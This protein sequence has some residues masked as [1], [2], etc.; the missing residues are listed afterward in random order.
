M[1][2]I[3]KKRTTWTRATPAKQEWQTNFGQ[4]R[5]NGR[6]I[7]I[8]ADSYQ[9]RVSLCNLHNSKKIVRKFSTSR[10]R[11]WWGK[12]H[13][14][15]NENSPPQQSQSPQ[16][17]ETNKIQNVRQKWSQRQETTTTNI[18]KSILWLGQRPIERV[19]DYWAKVDK[20]SRAH[21]QTLLKRK[22]ASLFSFSFSFLKSVLSFP[23][24]SFSQNLTK[25]KTT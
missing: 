25:K 9:F 12:R 7:I 21:T 1:T 11:W 23:A 14:P 20:H 4:P 22:I 15:Q 16:R 3:F 6:I 13:W 5:F 17:G 19:M 18:Q 2:N 24:L 8:S 10:W